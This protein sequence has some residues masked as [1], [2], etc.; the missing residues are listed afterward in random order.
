M[1]GF[2]HVYTGN[3]KGKTTAAIGLAI[4]A[5]GAGKKVFFAQFIKGKPY[6]EIGIIKNKIPEITIK[7]YGLGCFIIN[8]PTQ[9]DIDAARKGLSKVLY[10]IK[11]GIYDVI[12]LDEANIATYYNLFSDEELIEVILNKKEEAEI[13]ITGRYASEKL[14]DKADLVTEMKEVKHYYNKGIEAREGIEY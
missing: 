5:A 12:I 9:Q 7:Q 6:S 14:I 11:S 10:V 8:S 4:R 1:P 2:I 3:G 13:I